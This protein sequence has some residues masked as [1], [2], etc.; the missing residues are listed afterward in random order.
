VSSERRNDDDDGSD[1]RHAYDLEMGRGVSAPQRVVHGILL[2]T[3]VPTAIN[4]HEH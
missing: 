2:G 4:V 1:E 3:N